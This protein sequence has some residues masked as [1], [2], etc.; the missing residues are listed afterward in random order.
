MF[1]RPSPEQIH[2]ATRLLLHEGA[3]GSADACAIAAGRVYDKLDAHLSPLLG[4][5]GF[6][7]LLVRSAKLRQGEFPFLDVSVLEGSA[8]LSACLQAQDGVA[9][10][11]SAAA[12]YGTFFSLLTTFI[13]ERL[14]TQA[15]RAAWPTLDLA[16]LTE[17]KK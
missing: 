7:A 12:L 15:L 1:P 6:Q 9:A 10:L 16:A 5:A 14:T 13:G 11:E 4:A 8:N 17:T 3:V 2:R